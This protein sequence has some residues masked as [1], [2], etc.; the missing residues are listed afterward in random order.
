MAAENHAAGAGCGGLIDPVA[1]VFDRFGQARGLEPGDA[2][3]AHP[4][5]DRDIAVLREPPAQPVG[6]GLDRIADPAGDHDD[7][8]PFRIDPAC[9]GIADTL[10]NAPAARRHVEHAFRDARPDAQTARPD[11]VGD[12][13]CGTV[14]RAPEIAGVAIEPDGGGPRRGDQRIGRPRRLGADQCQHRQIELRKR[15]KI[16]RLR[17]RA[18]QFH[19]RFG[20]LHEHAVAQPG[21][22]RGRRALTGFKRFGIES[23]PARDRGCGGCNP[24]GIVRAGQASARESAQLGDGVDQDHRLDPLFSAVVDQ[25]VGLGRQVLGGDD[26]AV[27]LPDDHEILVSAQLEVIERGFERPDRIAERHGREIVLQLAVDT[28][29]GVAARRQPLGREARG[30]P[31]LERMRTGPGREHDDRGTVDVRTAGGREQN[32]RGCDPPPARSFDDPSGRI[33]RKLEDLHLERLR[34]RGGGEQEGGEHQPTKQYANH[35][36]RASVALSRAS[37]RL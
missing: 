23:A 12:G 22:G 1:D 14:F 11:P 6:R 37:L 16:A 34:P 21:I 15:G 13:V 33:G 24:R 18:P 17:R 5:R 35:A 4:R 30:L 26:R 9:G 28:Q 29:H 36:E 27:I 20:G 8:R 3:N 10:Q 25:G 2:G 32:R 7:D 31:G 19:E